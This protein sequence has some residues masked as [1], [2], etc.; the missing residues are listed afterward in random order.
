MK[1]S[2]YHRVRALFYWLNFEEDIEVLKFLSNKT[3]FEGLFYLQVEEI[4]DEKLQW[5]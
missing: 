2:V 5:L 4:N 1:E 3:R